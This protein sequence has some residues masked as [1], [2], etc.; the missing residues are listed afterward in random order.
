MIKKNPYFK[1]SGSLI[2]ILPT[3]VFH[4]SFLSKGEGILVKKIKPKD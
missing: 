2:F 3:I 1:D 4:D